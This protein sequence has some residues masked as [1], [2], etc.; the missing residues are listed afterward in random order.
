[1]INENTMPLA[2]RLERADVWNTAR[3]ERIRDLEAAISKAVSL[4]TEPYSARDGRWSLGEAVETLRKAL[5]GA[6]GV[7]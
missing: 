3:A 4:L 6:A 2:E 1:M 5:A 7:P